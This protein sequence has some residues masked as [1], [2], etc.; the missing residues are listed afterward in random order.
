MAQTAP[1]CEIVDSTAGEASRIAGQ[2]F[3][4]ALRVAPGGLDQD[5][6]QRHHE[7]HHGGKDCHGRAAEI[8]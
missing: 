3:N 8:R 4:W 1:A 6:G 7:E 5:T 2:L